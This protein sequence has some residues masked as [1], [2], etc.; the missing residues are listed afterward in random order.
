MSLHSTFDDAAVMAVDE[1]LDHI[2]PADQSE[3]DLQVARSTGESVSDIHHHGFSP[4]LGIP[5]ERDPE[6]LILDWDALDLE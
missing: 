4:L 2:L 6:D 5:F 1:I 3:L